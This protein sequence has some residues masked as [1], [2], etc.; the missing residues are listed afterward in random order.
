MGYDTMREFLRTFQKFDKANAAVMVYSDYTSD[1]DYYK[2]L[3]S[4]EELEAYADFYN[5]I[6]ALIPDGSEDDG[7]IDLSLIHISEPTRPSHI[8]RMPS[9]A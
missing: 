5:Y 3:I 9:S 4:E 2:N 6:R 8:S 7:E 1:E